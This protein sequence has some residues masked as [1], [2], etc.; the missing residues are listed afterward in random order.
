MFVHLQLLDALPT[1][2]FMEIELKN[3]LVQ[4]LEEYVTPNKIELIDKVLAE[5]TRYLTVV[6]EDFYHSQNA[7]A[8]MRTCDCF[9]VQD[10]YI[11]QRLHD[12]NVNPNVVRGASKWLSLNMFEREEQS[13]EK[14]FNSLKSKNYRLVGTTPDRDSASIKELNINQPIAFVFGT[15][16]QGMSNYAKEHVD[17]LVHVPMYGFTESF[18]VSVSA[19]L[20]LNELVDRIKRESVDWALSA[21][22][23]LDLKFEWYQHIVKRS[24]LHIKNYIAEHSH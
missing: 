12:Y 7:S 11:T 4:L 9:G 1:A 24:D 13:T 10:V 23:K 14:C 17:E 6:M 21:E 5:R 20:I 22:E 8:V 15:E 2:F 16:K 19:A 3:S 18:N